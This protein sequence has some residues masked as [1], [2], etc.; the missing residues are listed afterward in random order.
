[1]FYKVMASTVMCADVSNAAKCAPLDKK[2]ANAFL[3]HVQPCMFS[4]LLE[5]VTLLLRRPHAPLT[6]D[7][8]PNSATRPASDRPHVRWSYSW[9]L[10]GASAPSRCLA[11]RQRRTRCSLAATVHCLAFAPGSR[12][13]AA[14]IRTRQASQTWPVDEFEMPEREPEWQR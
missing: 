12:H 13:S 3:I 8:D 10:A 4:L 14:A 9:P 2:V 11:L 1:M 5:A 6:P 7:Y